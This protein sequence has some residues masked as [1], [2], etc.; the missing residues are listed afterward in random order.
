MEETAA[1]EAV[2]VVAK[3]LIMEP[4][5]IIENGCGGSLALYHVKHCL[6]SQAAN[7][8][9]PSSDYIVSMSGRQIFRV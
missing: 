6:Y 4:K 1:V 5:K 2:E 9:T 3:A 8:G 7:N